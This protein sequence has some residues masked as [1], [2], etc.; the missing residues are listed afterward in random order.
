[1]FTGVI[2]GI[3][4]GLTNI[5][6][7][8]IPFSQSGFT[9]T[10]LN[11]AVEE[12]LTELYGYVHYTGTPV[13]NQVAIFTNINTVEGSSNLTFTGSTLT[14]VGTVVADGVTLGQDELVT[15]GAQTLTHDGTDFVMD[16]SLS[17]GGDGQSQLVQG[18]LVNSGQ[19]SDSTDDFQVSTSNVEYAFLIDSSADTATFNVNTTVV[20]TLSA[21]FFIGDGSDI[22]NIDG[23]NI[24]FSQ[25]GF[26]SLNLNDAVEELI[27]LLNVEVNLLVPYIGATTNLNLGSNS[28]IINSL[29]IV[30]VD[31]QV[32]KSVVESSTNWDSAYTHISNNGSDHSYINQDVKSGSSPTFLGTNITNINGQNIPF[33][34]SGIIATNLN[35]SVEE[36][37]DT[38]T[39]ILTVDG[40]IV[41][42]SGYIKLDPIPSSDISASGITTTLT[43]DSGVLN[44]SI[45]QAYCIDADGELINADA[46]AE[47]GGA[48]TTMPC[49]CLALQTGTGSK[50]VLLQGFIR[51]DSWNWTVGGIVYVSTD[52]TTYGGLTQ[53]APSDSGDRVQTVG[54][55]T[56]ADRIYFNP[57][58]VL[59]EVA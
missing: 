51:N 48:L 45:G 11:D 34:H 26:T 59:V 47:S 49:N 7:Q 19:G 22:T 6:G 32:N 18:L 14:V 31:G 2:T 24:P 29:E 27:A 46:E 37:F 4:S 33:S 5:N 58:F 36:L 55:A 23:Q 17:V 56:H 40:I 39:G 43:V 54:Y 13:D 16:D 25:S 28:L 1:M 57:S 53:T 20:G 21:T 10:N 52:P 38:M 8:N 35:D 50:E 15:I 9:A 41:S 44:T 30:G 12:L 3:G 42:D